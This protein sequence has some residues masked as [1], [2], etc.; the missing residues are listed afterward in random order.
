MFLGTEQMLLGTSLLFLGTDQ[1][2][3]G[4]SLLFLGTYQV[5][6]GTSRLFHGTSRLFHGTSL[7]FHGTSRLFQGKMGTAI[8]AAGRWLYPTFPRH[9]SGVCVF[10]CVVFDPAVRKS[11]YRPVSLR[12]LGSVPVFAHHRRPS[13]PAKAGTDPSRFA[14]LVQSLF[15]L[16]IAAHH[17]LQKQVQ[18]RLASLA[19]VS[20]CFA[21]H[22]RPSPTAKTGNRPVL[23]RSLGSVPVFTHHRRPSPP[24]KAGTDPFR[25]ARLGQSLFLRLSHRLAPATCSTFHAC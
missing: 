11:R 1:V 2:F 4:T 25:F 19:S 10:C 5:F 24:A 12:S 14:R 3:L 18:T 22:R 13:P 8:P 9:T 23:L 6:L 21:L 16:T 17:R 15:L 20:P 7:L